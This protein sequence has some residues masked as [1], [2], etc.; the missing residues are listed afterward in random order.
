MKFN[1]QRELYR[2]EELADTLHGENGCPWD[3]KQTHQ[4]L[5]KY[6]IEETYEV[7]DAIDSGSPDK[8]KEELGDLLYQVYAHCRVSNSFKID[9]VAK[10]IIQ[11]LITRHP[12]V[13]G[14][15]VADTPDEVADKWERIKKK[16]RTDKKILEGVP[17]H[18]PALLKAYRVQEKVSRVGFDFPDISDTV[19]KL[20]EE[21][22]ELK[23]AVKNGNRAEVEDEFGD[24]LFSIVNIARFASIDPEQSLRNAVAKFTS[25]FNEVEDMVDKSGKSFDD[26]T[27]EQL[28]KMWEKAKKHHPTSF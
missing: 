20:E 25:R 26:Y 6:L 7:I 8:L 28:D 16:E 9:D 17:A 12:H 21:L 2:L 14:E 3:R 24:I 1:E 23:E 22:E 13:F 11:K 27:M 10:M 15:E 5:K 19:M 4:S 18:L